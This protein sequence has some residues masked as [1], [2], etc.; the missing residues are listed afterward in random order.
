MS[1]A[2]MSAWTNV[3]S[4]TAARASSIC[5]AE[6]S[7]PVTC[8]PAARARVIGTPAPQPRSRTS[9]PG[10]MRSSALASQR[11]RVGGGS[12]VAP[13]VVAL[14]DRVVAVGDDLARVDGVVETLRHDALTTS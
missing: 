2:V 7:T 5:R 9:A 8:R 13:R 6:M 14:G 11:S 10:G 3:A 1:S 12:G 4:G